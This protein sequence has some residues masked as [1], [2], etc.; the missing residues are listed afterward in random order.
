MFFL[1]KKTALQLET[2]GLCAGWINRFANAGDAALEVAETTAM[3]V[4]ILVSSAN[5]MLYLQNFSSSFVRLEFD[6]FP[7]KVMC[8]F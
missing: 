1:K 8:I 2:D 3:K 5:F 7:L 4:Y 6:L